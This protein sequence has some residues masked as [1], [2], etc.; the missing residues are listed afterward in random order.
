MK[1]LFSVIIVIVL[2]VFGC[3]A[4]EPALVKFQPKSPDEAAIK[5]VLRVWLNGM[6]NCDREAIRSCF[7]QNAK[8]MTSGRE[9]H[10]VS[11]DEYINSGAC[12]EKGE[13]IYFKVPE[14][15]SINSDQAEVYIGVSIFSSKRDIE[16]D[17]NMLFIKEHGKWKIKTRTY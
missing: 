1:G 14:I 8:I 9:R 16:V 13:K 6:E 15:K 10:I 17:F 2:A 5:E 11:L 12:Q 7:T 3:A 4:A